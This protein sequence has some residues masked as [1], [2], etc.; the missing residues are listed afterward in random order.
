MAVCPSHD[1]RFY[2]KADLLAKDVGHYKLKCEGSVSFM[3]VVCEV[4][5]IFRFGSAPTVEQTA[6]FCQVCAHFFRQH[7]DQIIGLS[8]IIL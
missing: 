6:E 5:N 2:D 8:L 1:F 3:I 4:S 7:P